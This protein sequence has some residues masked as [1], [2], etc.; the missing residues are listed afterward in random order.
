M[1]GTNEAV[2]MVE[3]EAQEL[4]ETIMLG[5]GDVRSTSIS[6]R[7][8]DAISVWPKKAAQRSRVI[9]RRQTFPRSRRPCSRLPRPS[10]RRIQ[11]SRQQERLRAAIDV[12]K[13]KVTEAP[14]SPRTASRVF[15]TRN[16]NG[17]GH[18][19]ELQ[20][21]IVRLGILDDGERIERGAT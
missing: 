17:Q 6:S 19:K 7:L 12:A 21:K 1:A 11:A 13:A 14:F 15:R 5:R 3:S 2:L 18:I 8:I 20:A 10:A 4:P 9:S 16:E